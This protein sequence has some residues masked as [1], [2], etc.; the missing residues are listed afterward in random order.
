MERSRILLLAAIG[1]GAGVIVGA[2]ASG[3]RRIA[4]SHFEPGFARIEACHVEPDDQTLVCA[5]PV[6]AG[7]LLLATDLS[8]EADRVV[9]VTHASV[10]I[11]GGSGFKNLSAT[12]DTSR[13]VLTRPLGGRKVIDGASGKTV[14][15]N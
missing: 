10:Y 13:I 3:W 2:S 5:T 12:L 1:F 14:P 4:Q 8:E 6:G 9:L 7:D 15:L 11:P